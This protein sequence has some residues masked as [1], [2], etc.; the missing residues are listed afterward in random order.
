M[1]FYLA[2]VA[3]GLFEYT[4]SYYYILL[5]PIIIIEACVHKIVLKIGFS[6]ALFGSIIT[7]F[8]S[9]FVGLYIGM[10]ISEILPG[11][12][13]RT[14]VLQFAIQV[15]IQLIPMCYVSF[16]LEAK[17]GKWY[18]SLFDKNSDSPTKSV[19]WK[20]KDVARSFLWANIYSYLM[21]ALTAIG[22]ELI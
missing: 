22:T 15:I 16:L 6:K 10:F 18:L 13:R 12:G 17:L 5:I 20:N 21:L 2:D 7:N 4:Y 19:F 14:S 9:T 11:V 3:I 8:F 1:Q